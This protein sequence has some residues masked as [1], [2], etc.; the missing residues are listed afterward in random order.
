MP[1]VFPGIV[2]IPTKNSFAEGAMLEPVNTVL[3]AINRLNILRGDYVL[4]VGQGP[5][6]LMFTR[7]LS[8]RG[9]NVIAS[10]LLEPRLKLAKKFG[11]RF[12]VN[13]A[14]FPLIE[15]E[16][17]GEGEP[18]FFAET[19]ARLTRKKM[20]D[21]AIVAVPSD[22]AVSQ[23]QHL[24]R[25]GGQRL[26]F[27]HTRRGNSFPLDLSSVCVDEKDL[28]GSYSSDITLQREVAR[29]I[30]SRKMDVRKIIT[31]EF[32]LENAVQAIQ[33]ASKPTAE[34]LKIVV[35]APSR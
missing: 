28:L 7:L 16:G 6:G 4:V 14:S 15:G 27:A 2:K 31:H 13:P 12:T 29:L 11:A 35:T 9:I 23:M 8:L 5:I 32:P 1:F 33:L 18:S 10:D 20:L 22:E 21:A 3:K 26:L 25:G 17:R 24:V 34:S 30:F 19:I